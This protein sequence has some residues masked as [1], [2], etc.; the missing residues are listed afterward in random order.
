MARKNF[1]FGT[2]AMVLALSFWLVLAGCA[3]VGTADVNAGNSAGHGVQTVTDPDTLTLGTWGYYSNASQNYVLSGERSGKSSETW[4]DMS[5][6]VGGGVSAPSIT[7]SANKRVE[8]GRSS[9]GSLG[10]GEYQFD[11]STLLIR[12]NGALAKAQASV[13]GNTLTISNFTGNGAR[14][15]GLSSFEGTFTKE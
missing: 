4:L 1:F 8:F 12:I 15:A 6:S 2:L 11:G 3:S 13:S 7:F 14:N 10:T 9:G 5:R